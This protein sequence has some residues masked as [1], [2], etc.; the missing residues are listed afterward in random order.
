MMASS[1]R[2]AVLAAALAASPALKLER[3]EA[4]VSPVE[5]VIEL[6]KTLQAETEEQGKKEAGQYDKYACFCKEQ[7]DEKL[8]QIEKSEKKM[9]KLNTKITELDDELSVLNEDISTLQ[10]EIEEHDKQI[11]DA[12][13]ARAKEHELYKVEDADISG[14]IKA[15]QGAISALKDS[16]GAMSGAKVDLVQIQ[17]VAM[18]VLAAATHVSAVSQSQ[19]SKVVDLSQ[20][21]PASYEYRSNDIIATLEDLL[22]IFLKNKKDAD[23][24]EF[25]ARAAFE[26]KD[27]NLK[28]VRK[29]AEK[30]KG[31]KEQVSDDK[32]A[33]KSANSQDLAEETKDKTSDEAFMKVLTEECEAKAHQWDQRSSTRADEIKAMA[34]AMEALTKS[35]APSFGANKKLALVQRKAVPAVAAVE[36]VAKPVSFLQTSGA[37]A[38]KVPVE[39]ATKLLVASAGRIGSSALAML[40][41]RIEAS[42]DHF[43][44]V[45]SLIRDLLTRLQ[46]DAD[47][48]ADQKS[49]CDKAMSE[50]IDSRDKASA[51]IES[52]TAEQSR[53]QTEKKTLTEE[54]A[55]LANAVASLR[56]GLKEATDLRNEESAEN[57]RTVATAKEGKAGTELAM[58][59]LND[60]YAKAGGAFLQTSYTPP[61]AGR[62]GET[63]GDKAP[64]V[65]DDEYSGQQTKSKGIV[66]L[67][68]VILSDFDRTIEKTT[69]DEA[70]AQEEFEAF[71]SDTD[72]DVAAKSESKGSKEDRITEVED[73]LTAGADSLKEQ[74]AL[75]KTAEETLAE[76]KT[77]CVDGTESYAD[78]CAKREKEI[79]S[80]KEA[81]QILIDWQGF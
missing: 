37:A 79:A 55:E 3:A 69:S 50:N 36:K 18:Q 5:K 43:V 6:L 24:E 45:R 26:K 57:E 74:N 73:E 59:L 13:D 16:K 53:D 80:L 28:N 54:V 7:A 39:K 27:G 22:D 66:G 78:R 4:K 70:A 9:A 30:E 77:Q 48:E 31:E 76:L 62:D 17:S 14:A 34:G 75:L 63:F 72:K 29:F 19:L 21:K 2:A 47:A 8:Y 38:S 44:K 10:G 20:Q 49:F 25:D 71:E 51:E 23:K 15:M 56:K 68:E 11:Q 33:E 46:E 35:V 40:A 64:E 1:L 65:F 61:N 32:S 81:M 42:E 58:K 67:L 41:V 60:F 52:L 12:A